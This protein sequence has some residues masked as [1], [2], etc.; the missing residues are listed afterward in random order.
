MSVP[1]FVSAQCARR[2]GLVFKA[3]MIVVPVVAALTAA[4]VGHRFAVRLIAVA[5]IAITF[6]VGIGGLIAPHRLAQEKRGGEQS[7]E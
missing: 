3:L 4:T 7:A 2:G 1:V 6:L 5:V